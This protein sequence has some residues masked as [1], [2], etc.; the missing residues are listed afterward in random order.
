MVFEKVSDL[1]VQWRDSET[2]YGLSFP[3]PEEASGFYAKLSDCIR[4][5]SALSYNGEFYLLYFS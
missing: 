4:K 2:V 1:F 3:T 5:L